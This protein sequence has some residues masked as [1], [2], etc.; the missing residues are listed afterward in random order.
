MVVERRDDRRVDGRLLAPGV[1]VIYVERIAVAVDLPDAWYGDGGPSIVIIIDGEEI[2]WSLVGI[3]DPK[4]APRA[5]EREEVGRGL[6]GLKGGIGTLESEE[7]CVHREAV[8]LVDFR[9]LPFVA[10]RKGGSAEGEGEEEGEDALSHGTKC[11][12]GK[13]CCCFAIARIAISY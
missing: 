1:A 4:E 7:P 6:F 2:G 3:L 8:P 5:V 12:E 13:W 10:L 11:W 9:V